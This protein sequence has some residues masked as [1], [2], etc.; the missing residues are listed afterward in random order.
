V[1]GLIVLLGFSSP[2][3]SSSVPEAPL[4]VA[5]DTGTSTQVTLDFTRPYD[6]G[7]S[8]SDY[9]YSTDDGS[10]WNSFGATNQSQTIT[11]LTDG[12][13]YN[14][15]VRAVNSAGAG[16]ASL[17]IQASPGSVRGPYDMTE[18]M[19]YHPS[20]RPY[21]SGDGSSGS[22]LG[23][24]NLPVITDRDDSS[25]TIAAPFPLNFFG[26]KMEGL[27]LTTNGTLYPVSSSSDS[28][29]DDY[30]LDLKNLAEAGSAPIIAALANDGNP[31]RLIRNRLATIAFASA[32]SG[33]LTIETTRDVSSSVDNG[34]ALCV[35][36]RADNID[37][38]GD[39]D[40]QPTDQLVVC[41][42]VTE[43]RAGFEYTFGTPTAVESGFG[44][45][46]TLP[47][48]SYLTNLTG[49]LFD[50]SADFSENYDSFAYTAELF[51]GTAD[52]DGNG[53]STGDSFVFTAYRVA[54]Y[55]ND[56]A[57]VLT[58][59]WQIV[60]TPDLTDGDATSGYGFDIE[61]NYGSVQ[62][63][64]DGYDFSDPGNDCNSGA[65]KCRAG[66]GT[67]DYDS[68]TGE[69]DPYELFAGT[70]WR[71][72]M[73]WGSTSAMTRNRLNSSVLGRYTFSFSG[74]T[75]APTNFAVP[76]MDG[77][78][79]TTV[80]PGDEPAPS[81]SSG[82]SGGSEQATAPAIPEAAPPVRA[83][84]PAPRVIITEVDGPV[85]RNGI[86]PTVSDDPRVSVGGRIAPVQTE[87]PSTT[88]LAVSLPGGFSLGVSVLEDQGRISRASDGMAEI[89]VRK[90]AA[91][92]LSG[93]GFR[94]GATVQVFMP[95]AGANAKELTRIPVQ[96]DGSFDGS[97][98]FATRPNE[99]PLPIGRNV[100]QLV[101]LDNDGNQVVVEM[102]VNIAQASPAPEQNRIDGVVPRMA[103]GQSVATSGGEPIPVTITPVSEQKLAVV[104]GDGWTMAINVD[105]EDG[106]V[107]P[108]EGGAL[109]KLVRDES[110]V[111]SGSGFMPGTRADVWLFSDPTLLGSVT[112]DENG[113]FTGEVNVDSNVIS[114]GEHTLQLQGVGED[115]YV[116]A[117]NLGVL[118][119][120]S[121]EEMPT[122]VESASGLL[123]WIVGAFLLALLFLLVLLARRRRSQ[124]Q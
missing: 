73:D 93:S 113:E 4:I 101:S 39:E 41:D 114:L 121:S 89:A 68:V 40:V 103:P 109:L 23:A 16:A 85:L 97:A 34:D 36:L 92:S 12:T 105:A 18:A 75:G 57:G 15:K 95:L 50:D 80:R 91:A 106:G 42:T 62:D 79:T 2:A 59:T 8:I 64:D 11:G 102:A 67:A 54:Q 9:E 22:I 63:E 24:S 58:N 123:W 27:C 88:R 52:L 13:L 28:C 124:E 94:P 69:G 10:S 110:A 115:G 90:G 56:N 99:A 61:F 31:N 77:S 53:N 30:D 1:A 112:I 84:N 5:V 33:A 35:F 107:E 96:Q 25:T 45:S 21:G 100:L 98:P 76:V 70:P 118:V 104:E 47:D 116:K 7:A 60:L 122:A 119:D 26:Q 120:D 49:F 46:V 14:I 44:S 43:V 17:K 74:T 117:A 81:P 32:S 111:I 38:G 3:Y 29:S 72:L 71:G 6:G 86:P 108:S 82:S 37:N 19:R 65:L 48:F 55:D 51:Q 20:G 87:I 78:G 66:I 83:V